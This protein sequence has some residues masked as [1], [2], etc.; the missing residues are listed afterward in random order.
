MIGLAGISK[1]TQNLVREKECVLNLP[2]EREVAAVNRL[3]LTTGSRPVPEYKQRQGYRHVADKF[4]EAGLTPAASETV[5]PA[6]VMECPVQLEASLATTHGIAEDDAGLRGLISCFELRI[7]RIHVQESLLVNGDPNR[8]DPNRWRPLIMSF[9]RFYGLGM[10]LQGS[11]LASVPE[12]SYRVD[13][14][15]GRLTGR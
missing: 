12:R 15:T 9:Q 14:A 1:T 5:T 7:Q 11:T 4:S 2:S 8:I 6:R 10:E 3:A 13:A